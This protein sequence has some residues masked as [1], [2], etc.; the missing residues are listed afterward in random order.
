[1]RAPQ[2]FALIYLL[3]TALSAEAGHISSLRFDASSSGNQ[4]PLSF[5]IKR[6]PSTLYFQEAALASKANRYGQ[7]ASNARLGRPFGVGSG[8][9]TTVP[10]RPPN[11]PPGFQPPSEIPLPPSIVLGIAALSI[12]RITSWRKRAKN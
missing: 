9:P 1:M 8:R 7:L 4:S 10:G 12:L 6:F 5:E 3:L 2:A 11:P